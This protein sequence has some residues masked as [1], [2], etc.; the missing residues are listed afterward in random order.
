MKDQCNYGGMTVN[1]RLFAAG[2]LSEWDIAAASRN[3]EHMIVLLRRVALTE[4]AEQI[5]DT[6]LAG[7]ERYGL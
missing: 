6:V 2:L 1:E 3:R 5:V 7:P 4:Q